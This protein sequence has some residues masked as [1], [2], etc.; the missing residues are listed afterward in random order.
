MKL[1]YNWLKEFVDL[2]ADPKQVAELITAHVAEVET[3]HD[4]AAAFEH[5]VVGEV[6]EAKRH[7]NADKLNI[8]QFNVGE[9]LPRQIVFGGKAILEPGQKLPIALTGAVL[10][11]GLTIVERKLRGEV[12]QGMCCLNSELGILDGADKVN[13]FSESVAPGT[14][15]SEALGFTD[16]IIEIDNKTLTHRADLFSHV[17]FARELSVILKT[18]LKLPALTQPDPNSDI[19]YKVKV[20]AVKDCKRYLGIVLDNINV[21]SSPDW[22]KQKLQ[23]VGVRSINNVVDITNYVMC[24]YGQ[25][26][27]AFDYNKISGTV[28]VRFAKQSETLTGLDGKNYELNDSILVIADSKIPLALAGIMGGADSAITDQTTT[29]ALESA[30]FNPTTIRLGAQQLSIRT[31]AS[32]RHEKNLPTV[33]A[34]LGFLRAIQLLIEL[35]DAKIVSNIVD[36][37]ND[38]STTEPINLDLNYVHKLIGVTL[39]ETEIKNTL[40]ALGCTVT[41]DWLVTSPAH[42]TDLI[43]PEELIEEIARIYGY[44]NIEPQPLVAQL[45]PQVI[46][47]TYELGQSLIERAARAGGVEVC[48]YSFNKTGHTKLLN[49]INPE[50][51]YLRESLIPNLLECI[52]RNLN[53]GARDFTLVEYGHVYLES[54]EEIHLA[55]SCVGNS[56]Q[57]YRK[58]KGFAELLNLPSDTIQLDQIKKWFVATLEVNLSALATLLP[59]TKP[60]TP[61][62]ELPG[63]ELDISVDFP[64]ATPWSDIKPVILQAGEPLIKKLTVFDIFKTALGIRMYLHGGNR[65]LTMDEAENLR[66][67]VIAKLTNKFHAIHRK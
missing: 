57:I 67:T 22:L 52:K 63:I 10:P 18:P 31:D 43:I 64:E 24:E 48:N 56:A 19:S 49:P 53:T 4:Q 20:A 26:L 38:L 60:I 6:L 66:H 8:G 44:S 47:S 16:T 28:S 32:T 27:H 25:P 2:P 41:K 5:I 61:I 3:I 54:G 37:D 9:A 13:F 35:A 7:P 39:P 55:L 62:S 46:E 36:E 40:T 15:L 30:T 42:R 65:T 45:V 59:A 21:K 11:N 12:S 34:E 58:T 17:G 51:P 29:V 1:S 50:L 14:L 33:L 23:A